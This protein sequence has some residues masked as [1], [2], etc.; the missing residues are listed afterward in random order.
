MIAVIAEKPSVARDIATVLGAT[1]K[2]DGNISGNGYIVTWA[3]GHLVGLAMPDAYGIENFRRENLP[4]LPQSFQL[5]PRQVKTDKG[6]KPDTGTVK[7]LKIIKEIFDQCDKIIVATDAG[8]EGELIFRYIYQY[9]ECRK[10]FVRLWISSLTDKAIRDGLQNLKDGTMYDNL[11]RSAKARSEADWLI[12]INASQ[13]LSIAAG[14]GTYSLGRVQTPTLA[15]ICS[16]YL[17]NKNFVPQKYWQLKLYTGKD[18]IEFSA[19]SEEKFDSQQPAIDKLQ[20]IKDSGQVQVKSVECKE[21]NQEP[22]LLY[23]LTTL[24]KE[25]NTKLNFSA[26]KTLSI[27]QKL[28]EGKLISYPR[29]GS[30]YISQDVFDEIPERI[31]LLETYDRFA[32]YAKSMK[33]S[34]LNRRSVDDKKV[35]DHHALIITEN[36]PG[37]LQADEQAI[38]ELVAGRMLEAFSQKC[39]KEVT[40]ISLTSGESIFAVKGTVI[41][42]A[43]WQTVFNAQEEGEENTVLPALKEGENLPLSDIELLEKQTKPKPLHTESSLLSAMENA[44][45]EL[46]DTEQKASMKDSGIGTPATRAAIIETLFTRQYIVREKKALVPTE[47]GLAVYD[48]VRDKK[49]ADV[50]MTGMWENALSKIESGK[51]NPDTFHKSTEVHASQI[52][53][54][55]LGVQ[56]TLST[57]QDLTCPKCGTGRILLYP[58]VAKCDNTDCGLVIFRNKSDKQLTDKQVTELVTA[59]KTGMI[60]GFRSKAGKPFDASLAFDDQFNVVFVFPEKKGKSRK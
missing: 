14:R 47:K 20:I 46:E 36:K 2:N 28:Y 6:Y 9:L 27:A 44:G 35:T 53:S 26:D 19:L 4:I 33:G 58:K 13:A 51:M 32:G 40:S 17:E 5:I 25:A 23:D 48:I 21:V 29:T 34:S 57:Q 60:K 56:L 31:S 22:P 37:S 54:E 7:Q 10:P 11:F 8:R 59:K 50:E 15:M 16:R 1:Q 49:I 52:T 30:R 41:K 39:V 12:G 24:Q 43:G 38:Y 18:S 3:F 55:L 42:S 45:K